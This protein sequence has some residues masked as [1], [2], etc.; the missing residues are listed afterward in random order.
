[1]THL[2]LKDDH[3]EC[4][5]MIHHKKHVPFQTT[6]AVDGFTPSYQYLLLKMSL[7]I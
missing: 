5:N 2:N 3:S 1:M 4:G 6:V 7:L